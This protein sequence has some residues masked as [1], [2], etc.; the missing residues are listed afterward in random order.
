MCADEQIHSEEAK[1][2]RELAQ[3]TNLGTDT[4]KEMEK[5]LS[6]DENFVSVENVAR[7]IQ[8]SEQS[9]AMRQMIAIAYIDG[10]FSP[11]E[12]EMVKHIAKIWNWSNSKIKTLLEETEKFNTV[13]FASHNKDKSEFSVGARLLKGIDSVLSR[14]LV[15]LA[16]VAPENLGHKID[17]LRKE[18]LLA[19]S[20]YDEAIQRC[21]VI[22]NE[23]YKYAENSLQSACSTLA[24]FAKNLEIYTEQIQQKTSSKG[25][26]NTAKEV[27]KQLDSTRKYLTFEALEELDRV[28][29]SLRAKQRALKHFSIAFIGKT[30]AG[31][32]TLHAIITGDGWDAIGVGKQR[33]T[34]FNRVYEWKNIRII[35]TPG[36]GAPGGKSDEEIAES[37]IEE[38]DVICYVVTI[39]IDR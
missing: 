22:A 5:I 33:T 39:T 23:D 29:E 17:K 25:Q 15:D 21:T 32:S 28:S 35:D 10:Y 11:L 12:R 31:K 34:R 26:A 27:A 13:K 16:K 7:K 4:I 1:A 9:E 38:S 24:D 8:Q 19:G 37:I 18:I 3:K 30:K 14:A 36:I 6:Q 2:L 20:G